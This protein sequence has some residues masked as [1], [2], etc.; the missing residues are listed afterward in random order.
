MISRETI[1]PKKYLGQNFLTDRNIQRKIIASAGFSLNDTLLEIGPGRGELT[2][3]LID[4]VKK[5][6]LVEIDRILSARLG[7]EFRDNAKVKV[8]NQ[9]IL[10]FNLNKHIPGSFKIRV[11]GNIPYYA[12]TAIAEYLLR[13]RRRIRDIFMTVQKEFGQRI[14]ASA[15]S[16]DYGSLSC[17]LQYYCR[18]KILFDIRKASFWPAPKV[19]SCFMR[20]EI[21]EEPAVKVKNESVLFKIIRT[22]F[23]QRRKTLRNSLEGFIDSERLELFFRRYDID[24]NI[25]PQELSLEN[26]ARLSNF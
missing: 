2:R 3:L 9:D 16:G 26:F 25:R 15:G 4:K 21:R 8:I 1:R 5:I 14:A 19:E 20:L 12:S 17:F 11:I 6:Y 13:Y 18:P 7:E 23:N 24:R 10:R 22:A